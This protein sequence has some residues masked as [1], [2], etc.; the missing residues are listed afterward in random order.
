MAV[1][2][3]LHPRETSLPSAPSHR[4]TLT[5]RADLRQQRRPRGA[6]RDAQGAEGAVG[7]KGAKGA[8]GVE[9]GADAEGVEDVKD[10][11]AVAGSR[12]RKGRPH[13]A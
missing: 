10:D 6:A 5:A 1:S 8:A 12:I 13:G 11:A 3:A 7:A 9:Q 4:L 2:R